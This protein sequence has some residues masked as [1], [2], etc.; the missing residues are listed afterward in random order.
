MS[1]DQLVCLFK[2]KGLVKNSSAPSL[3]RQTLYVR[4]YKLK[5]EQLQYVLAEW[6]Y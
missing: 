3:P 5:V 6:E 2:L 1:D 4:S